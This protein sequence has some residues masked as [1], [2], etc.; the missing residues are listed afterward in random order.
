MR[1]GY[2][3]LNRRRNIWS[4]LAKRL[5]ICKLI[6]F[7]GGKVCP[8]AN[9][10]LEPV[11]PWIPIGKWVPFNKTRGGRVPVEIFNGENVPFN[12][13]RGGVVSLEM[14]GIVFGWVVWEI[15][16]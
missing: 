14:F 7:V 8:G 3:M 13:T 9:V 16:S 4:R 1:G 15:Q 6:G 5:W 12:K 11:L 10:W 2:A